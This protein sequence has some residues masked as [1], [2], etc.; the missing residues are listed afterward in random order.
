[1]MGRHVHTDPSKEWGGEQAWGTRRWDG[2]TRL[3]GRYG[4]G[5]VLCAPQGA[6]W[7]LQTKVPGRPPTPD[8]PSTFGDP[9]PSRQ[10]G[11]QSESTSRR[12]SSNSQWKVGV[13]ASA[14]PQ[15]LWTNGRGAAALGSTLSGGG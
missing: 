14:R 10:T 3:G 1:M 6:L 4:I 13:R 11:I 7:L 12:T 8:P 2:S 9:Q 5:N 15:A